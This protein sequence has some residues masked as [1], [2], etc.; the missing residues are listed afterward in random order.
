MNPF[1]PIERSSK[2]LGFHPI[3][4]AP[5][6]NPSLENPKG[7]GWIADA[8]L[9]LFVERGIVDEQAGVVEKGF[10]LNDALA[11]ELK[12]IQCAFATGISIHNEHFPF[13]LLD[14]IY[15]IH[16]RLVTTYKPSKAPEIIGGAVPHLLTENFYAA[17]LCK[18]LN[19][20]PSVANQLVS[21]FKQTLDSTPNDYDYRQWVDEGEPFCASKEQFKQAFAKIIQELIQEKHRQSVDL[22]TVMQN[23]FHKLHLVES[24]RLRF[25]IAAV[26]NAEDPPLECIVMEKTD[27]PYLFTRDRIALSLNM[28]LGPYHQLILHPQLNFY[29][30]PD[31]HEKIPDETALIHQLCM[32]LDTPSFEGIDFHGWLIAMTLTSKGWRTLRQDFFPEL[33][34][35][36]AEKNCIQNKIVLYE[37]QNE[38]E[39]VEKNHLAKAEREEL[40]TS[41]KMALRLN[42]LIYLIDHDHLTKD[43]AAFLIQDI[44][45]LLDESA[46]YPNFTHQ[47]AAQLMI[48]LESPQHTLQESLAWFRIAL[49]LHARQHGVREGTVSKNFGE[50]AFRLPNHYSEQ[51]VVWI[52]LQLE[53]SID[54]VMHDPSIEA[55]TGPLEEILALPAPATKQEGILL[56]AMNDQFLQKLKSRRH[57]FLLRM[58]LHIEL[59]ENKPIRAADW[60][61]YIPLLLINY[62]QELI[63][64]RA[65]IGNASLKTILS[66]HAWAFHLL[67]IYPTAGVLAVEELDQKS[68]QLFVD[69]F[70]ELPPLQFLALFQKLKEIPDLFNIQRLHET[71]YPFLREILPPSSADLSPQEGGPFVPWILF[72]LLVFRSIGKFRVEPSARKSAL[73]LIHN[74]L[75]INVTFHTAIVIEKA[76]TLFA[77]NERAKTLCLE[78][79]EHFHKTQATSSSKPQI[80]TFFEKLNAFTKSLEAAP[81][82][83][84][85]YAFGIKLALQSRSKVKDNLPIPLH[86]LVNMPA[87]Y[88]HHPDLRKPLREL[89]KNKSTCL[90][91]LEQE[92]IDRVKW[93]AALFKGKKDHLTAAGQIRRGLDTQQEAQLWEKLTPLFLKHP[94]RVPHFLKIYGKI[95]FNHPE[96]RRFLMEWIQIANLSKK[97]REICS[98]YIQKVFK[99]TWIRQSYESTEQFLKRVN[100]QISDRKE[101][102]AEEELATSAPMNLIMEHQET[103]SIVSP[104]TQFYET[105]LFT[106]PCFSALFQNEEAIIHPLVRYCGLSVD[107]FHYLLGKNRGSPKWTICDRSLFPDYLTTFM[108]VLIINEMAFHV[109]TN[110]GCKTDLKRYERSLSTLVQKPMSAKWMK[111][112]LSRFSAL[113]PL[114]SLLMLFGGICYI[115]DTASASNGPLLQRHC[116]NAIEKYL[117]TGLSQVANDS[118][119]KILLDAQEKI[120]MFNRDPDFKFLHIFFA[121]LNAY[122]TGFVTQKISPLSVLQIPSA[123]S[124]K[125]RS[126]VKNAFG[127]PAAPPLII[128]SQKRRTIVAISALAYGFFQM[129]YIYYSQY[130]TMYEVQAH[131][132]QIVHFSNALLDRNTHS[133]ICFQQ[134][135]SDKELY[136]NITLSLQLIGAAVAYLYGRNAERIFSHL[137]SIPAINNYPMIK[138]YRF[139]MISYPVIGT[140]YR[141]VTNIWSNCNAYFGPMRFRSQCKYYID[142]EYDD[143]FLNDEEGFIRNNAKFTM[144]QLTEWDIEN[145]YFLIIGL[146]N[147]FIAGILSAPQNE[148]RIG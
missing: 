37:L 47:L 31:C 90:K 54:L 33:W 136:L 94:E 14:L 55:L 83:S 124:H 64:F 142:R 78:M 67:D 79:F 71:L 70:N 36:F 87:I 18:R 93:A 16:W 13:P 148:E 140:I 9:H 63:H 19:I 49:W 113:A 15:G 46:T 101:L 48:M 69:R 81:I 29:D 80:E 34:H 8:L 114:G 110:W 132:D 131:C 60:L 10:R 76:I 147:F 122:L 1:S 51:S 123:M 45:R 17:Y 52:P 56:S 65:L 133:N 112:V 58:A 42:L 62:P 134:D 28:Q 44:R 126:A 22:P 92:S 85:T 23:G 95:D 135:P 120:C 5:P 50:M 59:S 27:R 24:D 146:F 130:R 138:R 121:L 141:V 116:F 105:Y 6:K 102:I 86:W 144:C 82:H 99:E 77:Q 103:L 98:T 115:N 38:I 30:L 74:D 125:I 108:G 139:Q 3:A 4:K 137:P 21:A 119:A 89:F 145:M 97:S 106:Y 2:T 107:S 7:N 53:E 127:T 26:G 57:P 118:R 43:T 109:L 117:S 73:Q 143:L 32:I 100:E 41:Q 20:S 39:W 128:L 84:A 75:E 68:K 25:G 96:K 88:A 91:L 111:I 11:A 104:I 61:S 72:N 40:C 12:A 66:P 35:A 129:G